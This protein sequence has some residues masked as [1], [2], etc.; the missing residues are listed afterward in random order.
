MGGS[1]WSVL[2]D[3]SVVTQEQ[4]ASAVDDSAGQPFTKPEI[5]RNMLSLVLLETTFWTGSADISLALTPL[6]VYLGASDTMIGWVNGAPFIGLIG[7]VLSPWITKRFPFKKWY[8]FTGNVP[9]LTAIAA[10]G[11][12]A[13]YSR[14]IGLDTMVHMTD[15][16]GGLLTRLMNLTNGVPALVWWVFALYLTHWFFG[17]FVTLPCTEYIAACIPMSH[18]GRLTGYAYSAAGATAIGAAL[19]GRWILQTQPKPASFGYVLLLGW[20]ICQAGYTCALIAKEHRTPVEKSPPPYSREMFTALLKDKAYVKLLVL[21][22]LYTS[23]FYLTTFNFI[24]IYGF[25]QLHMALWT[26]GTMMIVSLVC[27]L[28]TSAPLGLLIDRL[29][30]KRT[31]PWIFLSGAA[32]WSAPLF[33][34]GPMGVYVGVALGTICVTGT[35]SAQTA[36]ICGLPSPEHRAGHFTIQI[37]LMYLALWI[38]PVGIGMMCDHLGYR[39]VFIIMTCAALAF[40]PLARYM[41]RDLPDD[42]KSYS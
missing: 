8:L 15:G 33:V 27:K 13:V 22:F 29:T 41:L 34:P 7:V 36:L 37:V 9:Y 17:G 5:R 21:Y 16:F 2:M 26:A 11:I 30:P 20:F 3:E 32:A 38:G 42:I 24:N 25:K 23:C 35:I 6:L 31:L 18:R 28:F 4:A 39:N 40:I 10:I 14:Q 19:L 1:H 12:L